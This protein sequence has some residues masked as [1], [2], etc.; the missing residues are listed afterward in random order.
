MLAVLALSVA[1]VLVVGLM[2]RAQAR[3]R[4][5]VAVERHELLNRIQAP[6]RLPVAP[7]PD[8]VLPEHEPDEWNQVGS[9]TFDPDY[10][11]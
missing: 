6:D 1:L 9:V 4:A 10:A 3:E 7:R 5:A 8:F 2:L 11:G